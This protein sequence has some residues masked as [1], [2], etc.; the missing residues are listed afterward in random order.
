MINST[1]YNVKV[2]VGHI[3]HITLR[4][5][6]C[7]LQLDPLQRTPRVFIGSC[8]GKAWILRVMMGDGWGTKSYG[9]LW[10]WEVSGFRIA[11]KK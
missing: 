10:L 5:H 9:F 7:L 2:R 1:N 3:S 11:F 8:P 4:D 6:F